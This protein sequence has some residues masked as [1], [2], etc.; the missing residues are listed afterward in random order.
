MSAQGIRTS[1]SHSS[2]EAQ[3]NYFLLHSRCQV[4]SLLIWASWSR[5]R[6]VA[7]LW[8]RQ[9]SN[10]ACLAVSTSA[11]GL[12]LAAEV[13][14]ALKS[15]RGGVEPGSIGSYCASPSEVAYRHHQSTLSSA[16]V[17]YSAIFE[18]NRLVR[19]PRVTPLRRMPPSDAGREGRWAWVVLVAMQLSGF[20]LSFLISF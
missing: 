14:C 9:M 7:E 18:V 17:C 15:S 6:W 16:C 19:A 20:Q 10:T 13:I 3:L 12:H 1:I 11:L 2:V 5:T 8:I 4:C